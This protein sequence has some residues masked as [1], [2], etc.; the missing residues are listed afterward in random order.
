M[1]ES[2]VLFEE[3][4]SSNGKAVAIATLNAEKAL[5]ALSLD[6]VRLLRSQLDKWAEDERIA[7]V[8]M[9]GSGDKAFCAGGDI[10]QLY[11]GMKNEVTEVDQFF[12]EEY[13]LDYRIH[14]YAKPIVLW[15]NG[16][17][18]GGGL[19]LMTGCSHRIVTEST[20]MAMPEVTIGLFPDVG[21]TWFLNRAP[22]RTGLFLGL[23]G[24]S[25]NAS[26]AIYVGLADHFIA[27]KHREEVIEAIPSIDWSI[28]DANDLI[29]QFLDGYEKSSSDERPAGNVEVHFDHIQNVTQGDSLIDIVANIS[30]YSGGESPEKW[31]LKAAKGLASGCPTTIHL[32]WQQLQRGG[33]LTLAQVFNMEL[34]MAMNC[35]RLGNFQ[36][37]VRALL[38]EKDRTPAFVPPTLEEVGSAFVEQHFS[39]PDGVKST[40]NI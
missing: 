13:E 2:V 27:D 24:A 30:S 22:G 34:A 36:E 29:A 26:D 19:G 18:M 32:V 12:T 6:M 10:V 23:T 20:R 35:A 9:Q 5:N 25:V 40:L 11:N 8:I 17:V 39:M 15:G 31:L 7:C 14:T 21:G 1:S 33:D 37:G 4:P 16:I 3:R 28:G 38:I